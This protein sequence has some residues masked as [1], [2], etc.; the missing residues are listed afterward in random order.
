MSPV[1]AP[2]LNILLIDDD[3]VATDGVIRSLRKVPLDCHIVTAEDGLEGLEI[4]RGQH[5]EREIGQPLL[6]V[7][8]LN[9][10]RMDGLEFLAE[11]RADENLHGTVAFVLTTSNRDSDR[12]RAYQ[13]HIAG[14]MVKSELGPQF[15]KLAELLNTYGQS[16][17]LP[18][19]GVRA[20]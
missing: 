7:V 4:L 3:D 14:Y 2:A 19:Y 6:V 15:S 8:D 16:I 10:P 13:K 20:P 1:T 9:M 11:L 12:A 17:I 5:P 18:V